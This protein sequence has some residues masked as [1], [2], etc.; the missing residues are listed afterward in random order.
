MSA[1]DPSLID[2]V[3]PL[4]DQGYPDDLAAGDREPG[5]LWDCCGSAS[6]KMPDALRIPQREW[7]SRAAENDRNH[8][9][10]MNYIDRYTNQQ[11]T[12]ECTC[13]SLTRGFEGARNRQRGV[14]F[15]DGP[16]K[17]FRYPESATSGSVWVSPESIYAQVNPKTMRN[18][19]QRGG[20]SV[21]QVMEVACNTGLLPD[22]VQPRE[23]GFKHTLHGTAGQG[24]M[25]Q[26]H[27]PYISV[28][29]FPEGWQET[30]KH[31]RPLEVIFP[32]SW[33]DAVSLV[34]NGLFVCVGR[35]GHAI[36]WGRW[37]AEQQVMAYPDS[38]NVTRYDSLRTVRRAWQGSFAIATVTAPDDWM[39][40]AT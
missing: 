3:L 20:A 37:D 9:W 12:H 5:V 25:N 1:I 6:R 34:L 29:D 8:T 36:P 32:E 27:G 19:Y 21:R 14:I 2:V 33:E 4:D 11:P 38:Y 35:D 40:P 23:Y 26:S 10:P 7:A 24:N 22:K 30:S 28:R 16:K 17:E 13:H 18:P 31:F 39:N 15:A